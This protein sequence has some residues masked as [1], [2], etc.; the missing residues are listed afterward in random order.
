MD[1]RVTHLGGLPHLPGVPH[2]H[3]NRP[4]V[5]ETLL[6]E[7]KNHFHINGFALSLPLKQRIHAIRKW[8]FKK[9]ECYIYISYLRGNLGG[10]TTR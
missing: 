4:Y 6:H 1:R 9:L 7:N 10:R 3:V 8:P 2:L 5:H